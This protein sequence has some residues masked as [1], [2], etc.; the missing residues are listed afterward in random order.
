MDKILLKTRELYRINRKI[1]K[2]WLKL[3]SHY[4]NAFIMRFLIIHIS[5]H[6]KIYYFQPNSN[7]LLLYVCITYYQLLVDTVS[8][9][10]SKI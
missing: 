5:L 8:F 9:L 2:N 6:I 4:Y 7:Y 3:P 10:N 1:K